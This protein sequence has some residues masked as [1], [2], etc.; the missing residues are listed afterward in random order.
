MSRIGVDFD[1]ME[2]GTDSFEWFRGPRWWKLIPPI[3]GV[4]LF[5][6]MGVLGS[7]FYR[8]NLKPP[9]PIESVELGSGGRYIEEGLVK[10]EAISMSIVVS[11][12]VIFIIAIV[13]WLLRR[14]D[15]LSGWKGRG[16]ALGAAL[17]GVIFTVVAVPMAIQVTA[18]K[19]NASVRSEIRAWVQTYYGLDISDDAAGLIA[20]RSNRAQEGIEKES[21]VLYDKE[22]NAVETYFY[23]DN[24]AAEKVSER[25]GN[26]VYTEHFYYSLSTYYFGSGEVE[27]ADSKFVCEI[28]TVRHHK[29]DAVYLFAELEMT[30]E[31]TEVWCAFDSTAIHE[32]DFSQTEPIRA[33]G[34]LEDVENRNVDLSKINVSGY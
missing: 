17:L 29:T 6:I 18:N 22:G 5:G 15:F 21:I 12:I 9:N 1:T 7:E 28:P 26:P 30:P 27:S 11:L 2:K 23:L 14:G 8:S 16:I 33:I 20:N 13:Y 24:D 31:D 19:Y 25:S 34:D 10:G 3:A 4:I 32:V